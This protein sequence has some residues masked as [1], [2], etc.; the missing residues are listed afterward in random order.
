MSK[1]KTNSEEHGVF[2]DEWNMTEE[3]L[4]QLDAEEDF[5]LI[6]SEDITIGERGIT[7]L[8]EPSRQI[9]KEKWDKTI[10]SNFPDLHP[11]A[12]VI[13]GGIGQLLIKDVV[14]PFGLI[15]VDDSASGKTLALNFFARLDELVFCDDNFTPP[16]L[17]SH[18][19]NRKRNELRDIDLLPKI[20][21][22]VLLVREM[23]PIFGSSEDQ[24]LGNMTAL[25]RIFDGE[26]YERSSGVHGKRGYKG[27]YM[28]VFL[29]AST[30]PDPKVWKVMSKLGS[31]LY[32]SQV[33]SR[34]KTH[35]ELADQVISVPSEKLK[36]CQEI[37][38]DLIR[39]IWLRYPDG[40][41]WDTVKT[42]R[43]YVVMITKIAQLLAK[44]R[45]TVMAWDVNEQS[46]FGPTGNKK[47]VHE[48]PGIERPDRIAQ[49]LYNYARGHALVNGREYIDG[50][51]VITALK[52]ALES[53]PFMRVK[54]FKALIRNGGEL[55][56]SNVDK[57]LNRSR[58][59]AIRDMDKLV[60]LGLA[61]KSTY[62]SWDDDG[63]RIEETVIKLKKEFHWLL[64]IQKKK[65]HLFEP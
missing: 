59:I 31:R 9:S 52:I 13:L 21:D 64:R 3:E 15:L 55:G 33:N 6:A 44:Y 41:E 49:I 7:K 38:A 45:G 47:L 10:K 11:I 4:D 32:F 65:P 16:S 62:G 29:G 56:S 43:K 12:D 14:N 17:V 28:F 34:F 35:D 58:P 5:E 40:M 42:K 26:G 25:T 61:D 60:V 2:K 54:L 23:A 20:K 1:N 63:K 19:A 27:V 37:T 8:K 48:I 39:S 53:A 51:D 30:P 22:K 18:A 50:T 57:I 24:L 36:I 46:K